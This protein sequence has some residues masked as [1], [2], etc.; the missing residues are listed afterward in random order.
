M[1]TETLFTEM[2]NKR[3]EVIDKIRTSSNKDIVAATGLAPGYVSNITAGRH[4]LDSYKK[5]LT[6]AKKLGV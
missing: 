2:E 5:L 4:E 6:I 1:K 3:L